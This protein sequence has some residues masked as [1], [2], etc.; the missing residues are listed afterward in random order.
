MK[1]FHISLGIL[2][3]V[4]S[5][6]TAAL[7][8]Q[9]YGTLGAVKGDALASAQ[10]I[11]KLDGT[12]DKINA[13]C[14]GFHGV[15]TC[16][17]LAQIDQSVKNIGA[18][19]AQSQQQV[20]QSAAVIV[21]IQASLVGISQD[22]HTEIAALTKT[23]DAA[24]S[25]LKEG[26]K[27]VGVLNDPDTGFKPLLVRSTA[28]VAHTDDAVTLTT[29]QINRAVKAMA[30]TGEQAVIVTTNTAKVTTHFEKIIDTP[31]KAGFWHTVVYWIQIA[32]NVRQISR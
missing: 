19:A 9:T 22:V 2:V 10:V 28:L 27:A 8:Y 24:T 16:G 23:T 3:C 30:D 12:L 17:T 14:T 15:A 32:A 20:R 31:H 21:A 5:L 7:G 18:M 13:P 1:F 29:P 4:L 26:T 11:Q 25:L 6:V